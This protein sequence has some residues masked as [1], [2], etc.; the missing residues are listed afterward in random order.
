MVQTSLL[1]YYL[2]SNLSV[3]KIKTTN[4]YKAKASLIL[5]GSMQGGGGVGGLRGMMELKHVQPMQI[6]RPHSKEIKRK[7]KKTTL[8]NESK[9]I[10][11]VWVTKLFLW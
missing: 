10:S 2:W 9:L 7:E 8:V 6:F 3:F 1:V 4:T 11:V 5:R